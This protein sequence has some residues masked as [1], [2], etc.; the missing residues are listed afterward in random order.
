MPYLIV[1]HVL[2]TCFM[3]SYFKTI[4][5]E[6]SGAPP[7]VRHMA[8]ACRSSES[9][10]IA[11]ARFPNIVLQFRL[12]EEAFEEFTRNPLDLD[13]QNAIL[14]EFAE[15][16]PVM[17]FTNTNGKCRL[18]INCFHRALLWKSTS[19]CFQM[20]GSVTNVE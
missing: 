15:N 13:R 3:W 12:S 11:D 16:L 2:L 5:T 4:F 6:P 8:P 1:Y 10:P 14:R 7:Q 17:T 9:R 19:L 20:F 18:L